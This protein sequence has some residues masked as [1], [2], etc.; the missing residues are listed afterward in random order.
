MTIVKNATISDVWRC[1]TRATEGDASTNF[2][3]SRFFA[4]GAVKH[5]MAAP[6][7]YSEI[8]TNPPSLTLEPEYKLQIKIDSDSLKKLPDIPQENSQFV[9]DETQKAFSDNQIKRFLGDNSQYN[10]KNV[11]SGVPVKQSK[12][13]PMKLSGGSVTDV[14]DNDYLFGTGASV[15]LTDYSTLKVSQRADNSTTVDLNAAANLDNIADINARLRLYSAPE[16][17]SY[18]EAR[19]GVSVP[20]TSDT[21]VFTQFKARDYEQRNNTCSALLGIGTNVYGVNTQGGVILQDGEKPHFGAMF[22]YDF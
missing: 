10:E 6:S 7:L 15:N 9:I 12:T 8:L 1:S 11:C 2:Y 21:H 14:C 5:V 4:F 16:K 20:I 17:E 3:G 18:V 22:S 13:S 19:L